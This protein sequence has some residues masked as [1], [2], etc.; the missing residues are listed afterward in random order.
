MGRSLVKSPKKFCV[1]RLLIFARTEGFLAGL[2]CEIRVGDALFNMV[3]IIRDGRRRLK[4]PRRLEDGG[5]DVLKGFLI[6]SLVWES[7]IPPCVWVREEWMSEGWIMQVRNLLFGEGPLQPRAQHRRLCEILIHHLKSCC[8]DAARLVGGEQ[9]FHVLYPDRLIILKTQSTHFR[10]GKQTSS[11]MLAKG[12][13]TLQN[14][15]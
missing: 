15:T 5:A 14:K 12:S 6:W 11:L 10:L 1:L 13:S 4:A 2:G 3:N 7:W 9:S 8:V